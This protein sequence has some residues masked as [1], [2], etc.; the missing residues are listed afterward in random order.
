MKPIPS[1]AQRIAQ[2]KWAGKTPEQKQKAIEKRKK[3]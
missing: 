2:K 3:K 1:M